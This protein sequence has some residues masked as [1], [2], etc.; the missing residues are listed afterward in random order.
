MSS[1]FGGGSAGKGEMKESN[2]IMR[3]NVERIQRLDVP[4]IEEQRILLQNPELIDMLEAEQ[5]GS[6]RMEDIQFD[7]RLMA[8]QRASLED[9]SGIAEAG[10]LDAQSR[11]NLEE[12]LRRAANLGTAQMAT[13]SAQL[14]AEGRGDS[15]ARYAMMASA[16]QNAANQAQQA[17]L[18]TAA[19]ADA[20]RRAA[21]MDRANLAS[22]MSQQDM[23]LKTGKASAADRIAEFN[24]QQRTGANAA[25]FNYQANRANQIAANANQQEIYNQGLRQQQF[26]NQF[27]KAGGVN[28]ASGSLAGNLQ[29]QA[30]AAQQA[31]QAQTGAIL[32]L[33]GTVGGAVLGGPAG[34]AMGSK[35]SGLFSS[36][37]AAGGNTQASTD[38]L[39]G[40]TGGY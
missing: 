8:A 14:E 29:A 3:E 26:Q 21:I 7:P 38:Y 6:S 22:T 11:L 1:L 28:Q 40:K 27:Q 20:A 35:L 19:Q 12:G 31:Q 5:L 39:K 30:A 15:G 13:G 36:G 16:A 34:A 24:A 10:G 17:G 18:Q 33:A 4:T 23:G 2:R 25:N 37:D 9:I 32:N